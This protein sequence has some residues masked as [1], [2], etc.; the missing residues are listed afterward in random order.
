MP[1]LPYAVASTINPLLILCLLA[2]PFVPPRTRKP[3]TQ[4]AWEFW[5]RSLLGIGL[6]TLLA[7][8]GKRF[9][10]WPGH[11]SFPS[12]HET[13]CLA[14]AACLAARDRRWLCLGLPLAALM[15]WALV[16]ARFH[17]PVDVA[18]AL[19]TGPPA[20]LLCQRRGRREYLE[21]KQP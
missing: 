17:A 2:A 3:R 1:S 9:E 18:G 10:V 16:A 15:A 19:L 5:G 20:A 13:F 12:G 21:S 8:S 6:A 7:E 4:S 14:A 11:P